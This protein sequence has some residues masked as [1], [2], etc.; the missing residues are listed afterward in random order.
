[1]VLVGAAQVQRQ[2]VG[3]L[4]GEVAEGLPVGGDERRIGVEVGRRAHPLVARAS[5]DQRLH[6]RQDLAA[7]LHFEVVDTDIDVAVGIDDAVAAFTHGAHIDVPRPAGLL[8]LV[9]ILQ[10]QLGGGAVTARPGGVHRLVADVAILQR[11]EVKVAQSGTQRRVAPC[12]H[13][14]AEPEMQAEAVLRV[15]LADQVE[16]QCLARERF[17][18]LVFAIAADKRFEGRRAAGRCR[19]PPCHGRIRGPID[20]HAVVV[21]AVHAEPGN[22]AVAVFDDGR[23][24]D[25]VDHPL[26]GVGAVGPAVGRAHHLDALDVIDADGEVVPLGIAPDRVIDHPPIDQH[27]DAPVKG[28]ANAM[29]GHGRRAAGPVSHHEAGHEAQQIMNLG[30]ARS[31]D[32]F[33]VNQRDRR[34]GRERR[35]GQS[36]SRQHQ[37]DLLEKGV[38]FTGDGTCGEGTQCHAAH[39]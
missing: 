1:M 39:R 8:A 11:I 21:E 6:R 9:E 5:A 23:A 24:G 17:L 7:Q 32:H 22:H 12:V 33:A 14:L 13:A 28:V 19:Q 16:I 3:G 31:F 34:G 15:D 29:V 30:E 2:R 36:R 18:H 37:R 20:A 38:G 26:E 35:L 4:P 27:L 10:R 25:D